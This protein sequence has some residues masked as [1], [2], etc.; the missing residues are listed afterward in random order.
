[1]NF[2]NQKKSFRM[3]IFKKDIFSD[4]QIKSNVIESKGMRGVYEFNRFLF[5]FEFFWL[6]YLFLLSDTFVVN[7]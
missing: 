5:V 4:S 3:N 6:R 2:K 1:M 7:Y